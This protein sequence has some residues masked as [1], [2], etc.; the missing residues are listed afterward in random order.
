METSVTYMGSPTAAWSCT[1]IYA[2]QISCSG[3]SEILT[4]ID[5]RNRHHDSVISCSGISEILTQI[6]VT[7][8]H[9]DRVVS[10]S[11]ISEILTKIDVRNRHNDRVTIDGQLEN[12][13]GLLQ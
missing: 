11:G 5:V 9:H 12:E 10:C 1:P 8:I 6:Y 2:G 4:Q 13:R 3:I 7:N